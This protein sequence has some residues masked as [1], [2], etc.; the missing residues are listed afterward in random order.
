M[1]FNGQPGAP[2]FYVSPTQI[3]V[4]APY[5]LS[6]STTGIATIQINNN[7]QLSNGVAMYLTD[8][9]PGIFTQNETGI[10]YAAVLHNA[11]GLLVTPSNPAVAGEYLQIYA[12][13][14]GTVTPV[15]QDGAPGPSTNPLAYADIFN[16]MELSVYFDDYNP[17]LSSPYVQ[18]TVTYAGLTP[19]YPGEYQINAQVPTGLV[20][21]DNVYL[22][23]STDAADVNQVYI[24]VG[25]GSSAVAQS[26]TPVRRASP[27]QVR[28]LQGAARRS[29]TP[30]PRPTTGGS[31]ILQPGN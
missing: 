6:S 26:R 9:L 12:T 8:A 3:N 19:G 15:I 17:S 4:I 18:G 1:L 21:G 31:G 13:G 30:H 16:A 25:G 5:E 22:E 7:G 24:P 28:R 27:A 14:L 20:S 29:G 23:I 11:T 10:G 2:V